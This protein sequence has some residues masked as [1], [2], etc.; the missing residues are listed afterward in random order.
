[1]KY[2]IADEI[3]KF[4]KRVQPDSTWQLFANLLAEV[5][6]EIISDN[7]MLK[8]CYCEVRSRPFDELFL[9]SIITKIPQPFLCADEKLDINKW[10]SDILREEES[11][12]P[13]VIIGNVGSGKTTYIHHFF[14]VS[15]NKYELQNWIDSIIIDLREYFPSQEKLKQHIYEKIDIELKNKYPE[16]QKPDLELYEEIFSDELLPDQHIYD[17]L[18]ESEAKKTKAMDI[19]KYKDDRETFIKAGIRYIRR[20]YNKKIYIVLDN[21][22]HHPIDIQKETFLFA[23]NLIFHI[24]SPIILTLRD[25]TL[26]LAYKHIELAA[27]QTRYLNLSQPDLYVLL[28]KRM[29]F[30]LEKRIKTDFYQKFSNIKI[31][32]FLPTGVTVD[33]NIYELEDRLK[34]ILESFLSEKIIEILGSLSD[35]DMRILLHITRVALSSGY[36]YPRERQQ[37]D[38]RDEKKRRA[39]YYDFIKSIMKGNNPCYFPNEKTTVIVNL[40]ENEKKDD[41][42]NQ[43]IRYRT[44]KAIDVFGDIVTVSHILKFM[45]SIGYPQDE[46]G[47][48]LNDFLNRGLIESPYHEGFDIDRHNI[49][50]LRI[51]KTG[52]YYLN[53][54]VKEISYIE[55]IKFSTYIEEKIYSEIQSILRKNKMKNISREERIINRL[56][57]TRRF[58]EYI[59]NEEKSELN[60]V[61]ESNGKTILEGYEKLGN[62]YNMLKSSFDQAGEKIIK[63]TFEDEEIK[64][65]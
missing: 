13:I 39:R 22:D 34:T 11:N 26:S 6:G 57:S 47:T 23:K 5:Y 32:V 16:F 30:V 53:K 20:K 55:E 42:G 12:N 18:D 64:M 61:L 31:K 1:M 51:T 38:E 14:K 43:L 48:V 19:K 27:F 65:I 9:P 59:G 7:E 58:I 49:K 24:H 36:L 60:R 56:N 28:E 15:L 3:D 17:A 37:K 21:V 46:T 25:Y 44:L 40:F 63:S 8:D 4:Y 10:V 2:R 35:R 41:V 52:R 62:V 54:L 45:K 33:T 29:K 50:F